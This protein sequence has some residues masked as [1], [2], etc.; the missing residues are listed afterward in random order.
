MSG[1]IVKQSAYFLVSLIFIAALFLPASALAQMFKWTDDEGVIHFTDDPHDAARNDKK[2]E[3]IKGEITIIEAPEFTEE[4]SKTAKSRPVS[5]AKKSKKSGSKKRCEVI[6]QS[7]ELY[8]IRG[9]KP[10]R[11]AEAHLRELGVFFKTNDVTLDPSLEQTMKRKGIPA[12]GYPVLAAGKK[13]MV[14]FSKK[15]YNSLLCR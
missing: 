8:T 13:V 15:G 11:R 4:A 10:C 7:V 5:H 12:R 9:C 2:N 14:G 1:G 6:N 3:E